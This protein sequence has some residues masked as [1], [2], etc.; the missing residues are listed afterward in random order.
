MLADNAPKMEQ[1]YH[2]RLGGFSKIQNFAN[3]GYQV[4][5]ENDH[6]WDPS[7]PAARDTVTCK[8][9]FEKIPKI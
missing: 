8:I 5:I 4:Q 7:K 1:T 2:T 9:S 3:V 6:V